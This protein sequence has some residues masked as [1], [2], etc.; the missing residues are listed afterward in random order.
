MMMNLRVCYPLRGDDPKVWALTVKKW[1]QALSHFDITV[2]GKSFEKAMKQHPD[3]FPGLGRVIQYAEDFAKTRD[4]S[5][6]RLGEGD[7]FRDEGGKEKAK[8]I[9]KQLGLAD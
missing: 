1:H 6:P 9:M 7:P 8:E 5:I 4:N 3:F 2:L